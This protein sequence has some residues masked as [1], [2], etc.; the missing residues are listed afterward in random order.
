MNYKTK[1]KRPENFSKEK[2]LWKI[3]INGM[4]FF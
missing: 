4:V 1:K 2:N 3:K